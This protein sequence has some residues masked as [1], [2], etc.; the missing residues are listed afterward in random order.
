[1]DKVTIKLDKAQNSVSGNEKD[2]QNFVRALKD[3][4][5]KWNSE[6]KSFLDVSS[7]SCA[8]LLQLRLMEL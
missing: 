6:W 2:Y 5:M 4:T 3:T 1:M 7:R 8:S